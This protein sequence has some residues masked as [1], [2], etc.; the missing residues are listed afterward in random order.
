MSYTFSIILSSINYQIITLSKKYAITIFLLLPDPVT[1]KL[2]K[3]KKNFG[4]SVTYSGLVINSW[5]LEFLLGIYLSKR[6]GQT[7]KCVL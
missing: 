3:K 7:R 2:L 5:F 4:R 6:S 1:R